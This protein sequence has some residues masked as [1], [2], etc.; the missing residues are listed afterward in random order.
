M[1]FSDY[2]YETI[3]FILCHSLVLRLD[4][5]PEPYDGGFGGPSFYNPSVNDCSMSEGPEST[6]DGIPM[7]DI[8]PLRTAV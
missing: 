7:D 5:T 6:R 1:H 2:H 4:N 8:P 3:L